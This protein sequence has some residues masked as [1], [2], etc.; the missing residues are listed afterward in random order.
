MRELVCIMCPNS[1]LL[2]VEG[3]QVS[4]NRCKR[5]ADYAIAELDH[6]QRTVTTT[7]RLKNAAYRRCPVKTSRPIP[8]ELTEEL[9][10]LADGLEVCAPVQP[11]QVLLHNV[12]G[13]E[14]DLVATA[15]F[16]SK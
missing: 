7:V 10:R 8:R 12:C 3:Q 6:P 2:H 5:G 16:A 1:C 14:A 15:Y 4:G 11:G 13:T 9:M